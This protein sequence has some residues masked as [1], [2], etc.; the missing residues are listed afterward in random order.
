MG[1]RH[2]RLQLVVH[3]SFHPGASGGAE[4]LLKTQCHLRRD[5]RSPVQEVAEGLTVA[6]EHL[7]GVGDGQAVGIKA[8][9]ADKDSWM[10]HVSSYS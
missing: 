7:C 3:L 10:G 9:L 2:D 8:F 1:A 6:S 5:A 4:R